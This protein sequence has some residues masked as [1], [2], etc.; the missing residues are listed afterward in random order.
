MLGLFW[1]TAALLIGASS[2][3]AAGPLGCAENVAV[4]FRSPDMVTTPSEQSPSPDHPP[5]VDP[6]AG[7][8][9]RV[10]T[11]PEPYP[12]SQS[13]PQLMPDGLLVTVPSP[14]P[15]LD[16]VRTN[17]DASAWRVKVAVQLTSADMM[18]APSEQSASE[19][20]AQPPKTDPPSGTGD[21]DTDCSWE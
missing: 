18:T 3:G 11:V 9:V 13:L 19:L 7:A 14:S 21:N 12:S 2:S 5:K 6:V 10:T 16:T 15:P 20:G 8:G 4:Q 1:T 17:T